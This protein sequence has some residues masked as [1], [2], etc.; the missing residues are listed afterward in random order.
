VWHD[1][2]FWVEASRTPDKKYCHPRCVVLWWYWLPTP[3]ALRGWTNHGRMGWRCIKRS[4]RSGYRQDWKNQW[5]KDY[6]HRSPARSV[7]RLPVPIQTIYGRKGGARRTFDHAI[8]LKPDTQ[9][10]LGPIYLLSKKPL[11]ALRKYLDDMLK[12][13]KI[14]PSKSPADAAILFVLKPGCRLWLVV[15]YG[16]LNKVT[17]HNQYP[18]PV[19]TELKDQV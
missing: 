1:Y 6:Y 13:G 4:Q 7:P 17:V 14:S 8:D 11:E 3:S 2:P 18:I 12:Q 15:N 19:M 5:R 10:P 9:P 16:G